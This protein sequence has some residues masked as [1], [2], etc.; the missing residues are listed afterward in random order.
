MSVGDELR[1]TL[2]RRRNRVGRRDAENVKAFAVRILR[3][4]GLRRC[5]I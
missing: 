3:E 2:G 1:E 5:R 4:R